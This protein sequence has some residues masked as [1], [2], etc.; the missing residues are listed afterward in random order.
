MRA[1]HVCEYELQSLKAERGKMMNRL[2]NLDKE[3]GLDLEKV[4]KERNGLD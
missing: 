3:Y 4:T 1:V 2:V